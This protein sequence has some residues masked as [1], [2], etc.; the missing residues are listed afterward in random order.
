MRKRISAA[1]AVGVVGALLAF[2]PG[3]GVALASSSKSIDFENPPY[4]LGSIQGQDGWG[5]S[6]IPINPNVDQ[7]VAPNG[8]IDPFFGA[9]SFRISNSY[10][11]GSFGDWVFSPS[12][13]DAA[14]DSDAAGHGG[15]VADTSNLQRHFDVGFDVHS[16]DS[17]N[18]QPGMGMTISPDRGDGARMSWLRID[19]V[20]GGLKMSFT[21]YQDVLPYGHTDDPAYTGPGTPDGCGAGD[22]FVTTN[23]GV[24]DRTQTHHVELSMN[25]FNGPHNDV[26]KVYV[27]GNLVH[28]GTSWEDYYRWCTES[29]TP[30]DPAGSSRPVDSVLFR[31]GGDPCASC[32]G[33]GYFYDNLN[34]TSDNNIDTA[35]VVD[36]DGMA[37][38]SDCNSST[39]TFNTIQ[40][41][42]NA[43]SPGDTIKVCP[44]VFS[45]AVNV[46]KDNLT[47]NGAQA[48]VDAKTRPGTPGD[49]SNVTAFDLS[50]NGETIDGFRVTGANGTTGPGDFGA[51][52]YLPGGNSGHTVENNI[53]TQNTI[54][55]SLQSD[56]LNQDQIQYNF[57]ED[58][59][60][61]G[62]ASGNGIY[63]DA[64]LSN[65]TINH[66][67]FEGQTNASIIFAST[68][69]TAGPYTTHDVTISNNDIVND[70]S[71]ILFNSNDIDVTG[72]RIVDTIGSAVVLDGANGE[73]HILGNQLRDAQSGYSGVR[74]FQDTDDGFGPNVGPVTVQNNGI[75]RNT[76]GVRVSAGALT[77]SLKV[78]ENVI[79]NNNPGGGVVNENTD[80]SLIIDATNNWWGDPV[81]PRDWGI[82]AGDAV[83]AN[84][85][86]FPWYKNAAM[87]TLRACD[88]VGTAGKNVLCGGPGN[89]TLRGKGGTD[90][91]LGNGGNDTLIGNGSNDSLIGGSGDDTLVG[92]QGPTDHG[93]GRDGT[94]TCD[95][96]TEIVSTCP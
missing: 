46:N 24:F 60:L 35:L 85:D 10:T 27:D 68:Q 37:T 3:A 96:S 81:G 74:I 66:N 73:I 14:G 94:D 34:M 72:N 38:A 19:D 51:G 49:E 57:F 7:E 75:R 65:A 92:G 5:G 30:S 44:G 64:G 80:D 55:M 45:E 16:A 48:G 77:G 91:L 21:D 61:P 95:P 25:F 28:T 54:G 67:R 87:T 82:G 1:M 41:A 89:D 29:Q 47:V 40:S 76:Y 33:Q 93:Q 56:G 32:D 31:S 79:T 36:D 50:G 88:P 11:S 8:A 23:L 70:A 9:Q 71:V 78:N 39:P 63:S 20:A 59:N 43:A 2:I 84:V 6:G 22:D 58:N 86:F 52:F 4:T 15:G 90:L 62:P 12:L 69:L 18:A 42:V 53:I 26:V 13:S 83:S 17:L